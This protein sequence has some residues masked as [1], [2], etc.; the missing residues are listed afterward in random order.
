MERS[1]A[2]K[3]IDESQAVGSARNWAMLDKLLY[4]IDRVERITARKYN[5]PQK[6]DCGRK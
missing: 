2:L 5:N 1:E 3:L 6:E 4:L